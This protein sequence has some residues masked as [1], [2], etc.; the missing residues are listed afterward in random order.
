M[1]F[2]QAWW[3]SWMMQDSKCQDSVVEGRLKG[4][5]CRKVWILL[6]EKECLIPLVY[7][8]LAWMIAF[9]Q[10]SHHLSSRIPKSIEMVPTHSYPLQ[11]IGCSCWTIFSVTRC[12]RSDVSDSVSQSWLAD[13]TDVTLESEDHDQDEDKNEDEDFYLKV[14]P[15]IFNLKV[16]S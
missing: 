6:S 8:E 1:K 11:I 9:R 16:L 10:L 7:F 12:W 14:K 3:H 2:K 4:K 13:F 5:E 15:E